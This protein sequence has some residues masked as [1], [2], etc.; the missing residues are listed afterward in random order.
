MALF[1]LN[2]DTKK[3]LGMPNFRCGGL[4]QLLRGK[5]HEI[6]YKAREEQSYVIYWMLELYEKH[7]PDW[8]FKAM[9][10]LEEGK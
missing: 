9:K 5:G 2:E 10:Y 1:E 7:G 6:P 8:R 4:A 3:I